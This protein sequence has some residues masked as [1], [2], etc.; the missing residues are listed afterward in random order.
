MPAAYGTETN[1]GRTSAS[2]TG[3]RCPMAHPSLS[4]YTPVIFPHAGQISARQLLPSPLVLR[5]S[6]SPLVLRMS[7]TTSASSEVAA[8]VNP[9]FEHKVSEYIISRCRTRGAGP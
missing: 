8:T 3:A 7:R 5:M 6:P 1:A 9:Q 4:S 2:A